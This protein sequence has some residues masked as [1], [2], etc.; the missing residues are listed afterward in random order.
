MPIDSSGISGSSTPHVV[1]PTLLSRLWERHKSPWSWFARP[2][3]GAT[4]FY[5]AWLRSEWLMALGLVGVATSWFWFPK[6][7]VVPRWVDR[8]IDIERTYLTPP[9]TSAKML[10]F[11]IT[12]LYLAL[13]I[14]AFWNRRLEL[15]LGFV[16]A[17]C[18]LKAVWSVAVARR[19]ALGAV[20]ISLVS[21]AIAGLILWLL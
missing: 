19:A 16:L 5:G 2:V 7:R 9:W 12:L 21:A 8:F 20:I 14:A 11:T 17:G 4:L 13:T 1:P 15:A 6:P 3:F 18:L 10:G